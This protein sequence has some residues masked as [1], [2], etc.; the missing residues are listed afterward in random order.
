MRIQAAKHEPKIDWARVNCDLD[1]RGFVLVPGVL[2]KTI[3]AEIA[4]YYVDDHRFRS[5]IEM[6]R[7]SFGQGE[8]KYFNY[9]L[10]EI[11]QQLRASIYPQ[12]A[13]LADQW[14]ERLGGNTPRYPEKLAAFLDQCHRA[15]QKR[16]TPLLLK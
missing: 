6:A 15:G 14:S 7:Y 2:S 13:P 4:D 9:P 8:Y 16:A 1:E 5:R 11:V 12:L 3:C 10:P